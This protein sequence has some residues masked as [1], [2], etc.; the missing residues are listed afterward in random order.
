DLLAQA[1]PLVLI[2]LVNLPVEVFFITISGRSIL[3]YYLTALP[4]MAILAGILAYTIPF[5]VETLRRGSSLNT[6]RW[7][8]GVVLAA[9][10]LAQ[11]G[12]ATYYPSYV[13]V[14][15]DNDYAPVIDYVAKNTKP[16]QQ[17]L[18]IGAE[19]VVNFLAQRE[20]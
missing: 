12:Q 19:S 1:H 5:L 11:Y 3:H 8:P 6:Q 17:V 13:Q 2:G 4:V 7:A 15:S 14:L 9:V 18:L 20:A 10:L 16:D